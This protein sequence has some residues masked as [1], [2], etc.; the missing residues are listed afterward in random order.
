MVQCVVNDDSYYQYCPSTGAAVAFAAIFGLSTFIHFIQAIVYRKGFCWVIIMA[1]IWE[2]AGFV[3]R[4]YSSLNVFSPAFGVPSELLVLL[5]PLWINAFDYMVLGRLVHYY[6]PG[7]KIGGIR[8]Q[9][10]AV[11]FVLLDIVSFVVQGAGGSMANPSSSANIQKIGIHVY[12]AGIG[13]QEFFVLIFM[14]LTIQAYRKL[15]RMSE[16][17]RPTNWRII[18]S[19]LLASL[20]LITIRI[21]YRLVE[22]SQGVTSTLTTHETPFYCLDALPMSIALLLFNIWHPGR[23]LVGPESEFPKKQK[24][25]KKSKK[26]KSEKGELD[27][28]PLHSV[29][30]YPVDQY[31]VRSE[32]MPV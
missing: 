19:V 23:F 31:P 29:D 4:I 32:Y 3:T 14:I 16:R 2:T 11:C 6:L 10:L 26:S 21:V 25:D 24:K 13:I 17:D 1:G 18:F 9:R 15:N 22:F 30:Q 28:I 20:T 12:M 27:L 8:P 7:H 5:A